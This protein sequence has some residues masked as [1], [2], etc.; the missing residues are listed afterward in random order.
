[1]TYCVV[2]LSTGKVSKVTALLLRRRL[3]HFI[4]M[5]INLIIQ[6]SPFRFCFYPKFLLMLQSLSARDENFAKIFY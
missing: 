1:M 4:E 6:A 2:A 3:V 5:Q